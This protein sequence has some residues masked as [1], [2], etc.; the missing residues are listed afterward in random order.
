MEARE[1]VSDREKELEGEASTAFTKGDYTGCL[2]SLEKLEILRPTDCVLAH[3]K[4]VTQC[5]AAAGQQV[6]LSE[7][8]QQLEGLAKT[9]GLSLSGPRGEEDVEGAVLVYN[10][11]VAK[12]QQRHMLQAF[13]LA[14]R[15]LPPSPTLSPSFARKILFLHCELSLALHQPASSFPGPEELEAEAGRVLVLKARCQVMARQTRSLKK[16]LKSVSLPG[17]LGQ[18]C[19]FVRAHIE[20]LHSNHRKSIKMLNS[21]V[22]AAGNRVFPHYY[23]N[24]G[25]LHQVMKKPNLAIYYFKNAL[26]R[27]DGSQGGGGEGARVPDQESSSWLTQS[28]VLYNIGV[29][30]LHARRATVAFDILVEVVGAHYLDPHVWFHLAECC[31]MASQPDNDQHFAV[32]GRARQVVDGGTG[33]G[34]NHKLVAGNPAPS[35]PLSGPGQVP[36]L[37]MEFASVCLKNAESLLPEQNSETTV[38]CEGVGYI[39]NPVTWAEVEQLRV[40]VV[41]AKAFTALSLG[42]FIPAG[43]YAEDLLAR[44]PSLPGGYSLLA[45][46]YAAE[47]LILQDRLSEALVHLDPD[48]VTDVELHQTGEGAAAWFPSSLETGK[49]AVQYNLAVGFTLRDELDKAS[50]VQ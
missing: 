19:E 23:N 34:L 8:V 2:T 11:A 30:L 44:G 45:H 42:D 15:L 3:N 7:V 9:L 16:E 22:Q 6:A 28:Q 25:C 36:S 40:A 32:G 29:S 20:A 41:A 37:S 27:L 47:S 43:Q 31:L 33:A 4:I 35:P 38:F 13:Q 21:C 24:L 39:G 18:T 14:S 48:K 26:D 12:F 49:A 10:L 5:R 1:R 50:S 46:L 17:P